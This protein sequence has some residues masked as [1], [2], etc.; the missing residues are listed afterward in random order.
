MPEDTTQAVLSFHKYNK[1]YV[2]LSRFCGRAFC[3]WKNSRRRRTAFRF[4]PS[5]VCL[6]CAAG[7][8]RL[9]RE[10]L[11]RLNRLVHQILDS[12]AKL[13]LGPLDHLG[14]GFVTGCFATKIVQQSSYGR[15][16][17]A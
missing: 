1:E 2:L 8:S 11:R 16:D 13:R 7:G 17:V 12:S 3:F 15:I 9:H 10:N 6:S 5:S 14:T 4:R